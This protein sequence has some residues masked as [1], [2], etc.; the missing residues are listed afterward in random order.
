MTKVLHIGYSHRFDDIRIYKKECMTLANAGY[1]V[2]FIT[3]NKNS[4]D[5]VPEASVIKRIVLPLVNRRGIRGLKYLRDLKK[6]LAK[7][8]Y[9]IY[10]VHEFDLFPITKML[11]KQGKKVVYDMHEDAPKEKLPFVKSKLGRLAPLG[12]RWIKNKD[13]YIIRNAAYNIIVVP[14]QRQHVASLSDKYEMICNFPIIDAG[15][16]VNLQRENYIC[17]AGGLTEDRGITRLVEAIPEIN[18]KLLIA[19]SILPNYLEKLK[20]LDGWNK[21]EYLGYLNAEEIA[22]MYS[23]C[24]AGIF[25]ADPNPNIVISYPIKLFEYMESFL[26]VVCSDFATWKGLIEDN[27]CGYCI[28]YNDRKKFVDTVNKLLADNELIETMGSKGRQAVLSE[29]NWEAQGKKLINFY[30]NL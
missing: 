2:T 6:F 29:Y 21:V 23:K 7:H 9:D 4:S 19:G 15:R 30:N 16:T 8:E 25:M 14:G 10:H 28:P 12:I 22:E 26:P 1:D 20:K 27:G 11:I 24:K 5:E 13:D 18:A 17:Y 3:S